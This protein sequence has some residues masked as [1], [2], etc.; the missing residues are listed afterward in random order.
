MLAAHDL[1]PKTVLSFGLNIARDYFN[2][3]DETTELKQIQTQ[4]QG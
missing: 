2:E 1:V 3:L 4:L